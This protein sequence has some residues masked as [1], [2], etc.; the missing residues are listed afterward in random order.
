MKAKFRKAYNK[1]N[2]GTHHMDRLKQLPKRLLSAKKRVQ[3]TYLNSVLC[4]EGKCWSDFY[5]YV[6][7]WKGSRESIPA[8]KGRNGREITDRTAKCN[9]LNYS[10]YTIFRGEDSIQQL[11][12]S[13]SA[14]TFTIGIKTIRRRIRA[15]GRNNW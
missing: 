2:L 4:K 5:K 11:Q 9:E 6:K 12:G 15:I 3:E 13:T 7:K 10:Y 14:N 8:I 1:R